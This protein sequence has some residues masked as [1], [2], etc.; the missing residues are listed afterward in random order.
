MT[1]LE[2]PS[3]GSSMGFIPSV[4]LL[5]LAQAFTLINIC[6]ALETQSG[7]PVVVGFQPHALAV[8]LLVGMSGYHRAILRTA[9]LTG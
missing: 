2:E 5:L 8:S 4:K 9:D 1:P 3:N 6:V 7:N